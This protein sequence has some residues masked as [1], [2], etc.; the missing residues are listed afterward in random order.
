MK[1]EWQFFFDTK[2]LFFKKE[3]K[4]KCTANGD[5]I[6]SDAVSGEFSFDLKITPDKE[7]KNPQLDQTGKLRIT[8]PLSREEAKP[9]V[10][11]LLHNIIQKIS[12]DSGGIFNINGGMMLGTYIPET[13][14]EE[15]EIGEHRHFAEMN[16]VEVL[17][18]PEF[19]S[20][21]L[22]EIS[23]LPL[24]MGL[25]S[26][27]NATRISKNP[28]EKFLGFF[29]IIE[30]QF[31]KQNRNQN[32]R[33]CLEANGDLL[34]IFK[35]TFE[36]ATEDK[37]NTSYI[38]FIKNIVHAR[39]RCAHLRRNKN[40]GYVPSDPKIS[41]EVEPHLGALEILTYEIIKSSAKGV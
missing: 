15:K 4:Y 39:H 18:P 32:L 14:E 17:S 6:H 24:D 40:F 23:K 25:I 29:K 12:F 16:M 34:D 37:A 7:C 28:I 2:D 13:P 19:N 9:I 41:E 5:E 35:R 21:S 36:F 3:H 31:P 30:S 38:E 26:Q 20:D 11:G 27:H 10:H 1:T 8:L 22:A 33:D